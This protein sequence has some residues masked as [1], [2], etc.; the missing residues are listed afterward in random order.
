MKRSSSPWLRPISAT[1]LR[2]YRSQQLH[3]MRSGEVSD[4]STAFHALMWTCTAPRYDCLIYVPRASL[5][6]RQQFDFGHQLPDFL[7]SALHDSSLSATAHSLLLYWR[8]TLDSLVA[9]DVQSAP[10]LNIISS[11]T[12]IISISTILPGYYSEELSP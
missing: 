11:K 10:S 1:Y 8:A 6:C 12:E 3:L 9:A 5:I 7:S 2:S 4:M